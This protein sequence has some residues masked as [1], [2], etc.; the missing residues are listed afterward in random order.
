MKTNFKRLSLGLIACSLAS[1]PALQAQQPSEAPIVTQEATAPVSAEPVEQVVQ[2]P[3]RKAEDLTSNEGKL[4]FHFTGA[5]WRDVLVWISDEAEI[6]LQL[7]VIPNGSFTYID[8][9]KDYTVSEAMDVINFALMKRGYAIVKVGRLLQVIDLE[10]ENADKLISEI[11]EIVKPELLETRGK[12]EILSCVFPLG[13]IDP[14]DAKEELPLLKGP[15][16][17]VVVM[18]SARQVK[19]TETATKL[20][21]IRDMLKEAAMADTTVLEIVLEHRGA[22]ELLEVARPLLGLEAGENANDDIRIS[23]GLYG[24]RLYAAGLAGQVGLL[25]SFIK[26]ADRPIADATDDGAEMILPVFQ[27]HPVSNADITIVFDVL[28]TMLEGVPDARVAVEPST[29]S[30]IARVKPET[31]K[32]IKETITQMESRGRQFKMFT[33]KRLDPAQALLTINKYFGVTEDGGE[34]PVVDGDPATGKLWVRGTQEQISEVEALLNEYEGQDSL[35]GL[36]DKVRILPYTGQ[37]AEDAVMQVQDLWPVTGRSNEIRKFSPSRNSGGPGGMPERHLKRDGEESRPTPEPSVKREIRKGTEANATRQPI[38][39]FVSER[40]ELPE[41]NP[42]TSRLKIGGKDIVVQFTPAGII[43]ASE[44][45]EALDM[46]QGLLESVA[47]PN[48]MQSDLPAI[49]WL[50]YIKADVA[51]EMVANVLGG[52]ESSVSSVVDSAMGGIGGGMLGM[53]GMGGGGGGEDSSAKSILTATGSVNIVPDMR[54]NALII[55]ATPTDMQMIEMVLS[56]IDRQESPEDIETVAKPALIQ[57]IYQDA[58]DVA[59]VVKSL[60]GDRIE[61]AQ[62]SGGGGGG[63]GGGGGGQPSPQDFIAAL[64]GGGRGGRGGGTQ[65]TSEASKISIAVDTKSNALVV[66]ATP[67]DFEEVRALV[68]D[69]DLSS[70]P[71]GEVIDTY[72]PDGSLNPEVLR[73]ALES[74]L[75]QSTKSTSEASKTPASGAGG[76]SGASSEQSS[77]IARR[78]E[79]FRALRGGGGS[80]GSPFG[81]GRPGGGGTTGGRPGGFGGGGGGRPGGGGG[82]GGR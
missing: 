27:S 80:G 35:A 73:L 23:V 6:S 44:D 20:I 3:E 48:A 18:D 65:A 70:Q 76:G 77:E 17:R 66:R 12:T 14:D 2:D 78:I 41:T 25:E 31:H 21:A 34:G 5:N 55:Q 71:N 19:V 50:K 10:V 54:L 43:I 38:Y 30:I 51:A 60:F 22:D 46:F 58:A 72:T 26:K 42:P 39:H 53:L 4:R 69:L 7:D 15:W 28:Q 62:S 16:G 40:D 29:N 24:D 59:E 1:Q 56:A 37:A 81:G 9:T 61:G 68:H 82:R 8:P 52:A 75:G 63:R 67:Q 45:V 64:R 13:S 57:V 11:A 36:G 33:L 79:A 32:L 74:I 47:T 49:L